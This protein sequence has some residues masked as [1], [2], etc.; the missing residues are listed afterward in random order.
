MTDDINYC[1]LSLVLEVLDKFSV[2]QNR[3]ISYLNPNQYMIINFYH[4]YSLYSGP[5]NEGWGIGENRENI[6][7]YKEKDE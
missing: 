4:M 6:K 7:R 1:I 2:L 3:I 5:I